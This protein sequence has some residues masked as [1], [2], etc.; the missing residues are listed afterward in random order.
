MVGNPG[1]MDLVAKNGGVEPGFGAAEG[2]PSPHDLADRGI[3]PEPEIE[4]PAR[5]ASPPR[6]AGDNAKALTPTGD[7]EPGHGAD[8]RSFL[9]G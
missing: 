9:K 2:F 8:D 6:D 4:S 5:L 7:L 3:G 1:L